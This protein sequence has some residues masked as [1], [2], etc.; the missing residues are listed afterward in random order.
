[1]RANDD[2]GSSWSS[3]SSSSSKRRIQQ[4]NFTEKAWD[5]VVG[6]P[7]VAKEYKHQVVETEHL[8]KALLEDRKGLARRVVRE[9]G[10][11]VETLEGNLERF[12]MSQPKV[13]TQDESSL[14]QVLGK[15][16]ERCMAVAEQIR[17]DM[18][19]SYVSVEHLVLALARDTKRFGYQGLRNC[20]VQDCSSKEK[21]MEHVRNVRGPAHKKVESRQAEDTYESLLK[22]GRD[23][24]HEAREGKLDPVIGRDEEI[25][26]CVHILSRR[27]KNNPVLIGEPGVGKTA[28]IEALAQR[29]VAGDVPASLQD[30]QIFALDMGSLLAGAKFR[31]EFED[32]LKGVIDEVKA[33]DGK[34][35]LFIDEMHTLVGAGASEGAMDAGNLLKPQLARGELRCIGATT[36]NEYRKYIEKDAAL[37][38]R[39][40]QVYVDAPTVED[41][42]SIL[43]G[44]R[45]RYELHHGVRISDGALVEAAVMSDRYISDRFLPDKAIDLMDEAAAGL[46]MEITSKPQALDRI[47]R[48]VMQLEMERL[49]L[50][51]E[52]SGQGGSKKNGRANNR[53][54]AI[55][56]DLRR[57]KTKESE[58]ESQWMEEK[59]LIE[60]VQSLKE[61]IDRVQ[62]E[63]TQAERDYDLNKAAE[64]KYGT[65]LNLQKDLDEAE[66]RAMDDTGSSHNLLREEVN[67]ADICNVISKW[68]GIP[69]NKLQQS[70]REKLLTLGD[71]LHERVIGQDEAVTAVADAIQRS[72]AGL[73][74]PRRPTA[75][76]FFMGPTGVGK[77]ELA[78]ALAGL[79]FES[80]DAL[81]RIDMSEYMEKHTV[82]RLIGAPPGYVGHEEGGQLTEA[83]RRRPYSVVLFDEME[84]AH[85]EVFN[86]LLQVLDDGRITDSQGR[87]VDFKN[88][89]I[90]MTSNVGSSHILEDFEEHG[91]MDSLGQERREKRKEKMMQSVH[92]QFRPEFINRVDD[93]IVFEPLTEKQIENIVL[94][95]LERLKDRLK[96]RKIS[97]SLSP[98]ALE[99]LARKGYDPVFGARP[100]K[101]V[102]RQ[103]I[104]NPLAKLLLK[105]S[106]E[107]GSDISIKLESRSLDEEAIDGNTFA[108]A[109]L[110]FE[111]AAATEESFEL[112]A[113]GARE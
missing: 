26:R 51:R 5:A 30:R 111:N 21:M 88:C 33:S 70:E 66:A 43:R 61:E 54:D 85:G 47:T 55:E 83:I 42:I 84:K 29:V 41:T 64:L 16:L 67:A 81:V 6:A 3:S 75:S 49:S 78:K 77:T 46:K 71:Q 53:L 31:G 105:G 25:R 13:E 7:E 101:R 18:D 79:M 98:E 69:V 107:E 68:T 37:E 94:L 102:M 12:L 74:D 27:S 93:F 10:G 108:D 104:E 110:V 106:F 48:K 32:R 80:E 35:V 82:S 89:V 9:C 109:K 97:I 103:E 112:S 44:L 50:E 2:D 22:Y 1:M 19:D 113:A 58:L 34:V 95:Q 4:K 87:L 62:I 14:G 59:G 38:R 40:Q 60:E 57:L 90:I 56:N 28:V 23:L 63:I 36:L 17:L 76:F 72:R 65:L 20:G 96:D 99:Y 73:A 52:N 11:Q 92:Q 15:N 100:V 39:F 45:E 24:T 91:N 86:I 8:M